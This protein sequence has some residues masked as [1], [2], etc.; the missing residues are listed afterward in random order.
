MGVLDGVRVVVTRAVQQA[1]ELA[2]PLREHGADVI[3]LPTIGIAPPT[4]P[5]P[6]RDAARKVNSYSWIIFTS[7]NAVRVF[8]EELRTADVQAT[9]PRVAVVGVATSK[10]A[11]EAG[12]TVSSV[13]EEY[14]A[15]S[16]V[17][18]FAQLDLGGARILIPSAAVTRD[19][20]ATALREQGAEVDV[21]EAYRNVAPSEAT[22]LAASVFREPYPDWVTFASS[23]AVDNLVSVVGIDALRSAAIASIGP[24]TSNTVR[25]YG[26]SVTAEAKEHTIAGLL[27]ALINRHESA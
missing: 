24:I 19:V 23:S 4:D 5:E 14:V 6:L 15:E 11:E 2:R 8:A 17:R 18:A 16:L 22:Q 25:A 21:V 27:E 9:V 7:A 1:E 20:V 10:V 13:P 26:L 3:L 12:F